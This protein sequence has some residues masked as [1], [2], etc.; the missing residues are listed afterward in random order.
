MER[1]RID[2]TFEEKPYYQRKLLIGQVRQLVDTLQGVKIDF[3]NPAA[4]VMSMGDKLP[5]ALA[6]VLTPE[7][8]HPKDKNLT[9]LAEELAF[10]LTPDDTM[11]V[12][13]DFF[14]L[15]DPYSFLTRF[16]QTA[17]GIEERL[18]KR[19]EQGTTG[20]TSSSPSS[21]EATSPAAT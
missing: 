10:A 5:Q 1:T 21:P 14:S 11:R 9:T 4:L 12:V 20:S 17:R 18:R 3:E 15:N 7:N 6:V 16:A 19:T 8:T 2:Y 13:D